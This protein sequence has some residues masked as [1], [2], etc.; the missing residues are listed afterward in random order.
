MAIVQD[1]VTGAASIANGSTAVTGVGTAW[2]AASVRPG[3]LFMRAG[4]AVPI[5]SVTDNTHL[6]LAENWPGTTLAG[7]TYRI[8]FQ[9]DGS[10][11]TAAATALIELL[12]DGDLAAIAALTSAA[13]KLPYFT[14]PGTAGLADFT[15]YARS[16]L[17][18]ADEPSLQANLGIVSRIRK[19]VFTASGTYT[20]DP[21]ML[22][23][24][25]MCLGAGGG[26]GGITGTASAATG[27][28]GGGAGS[29]SR[30]VLSKAD[31]GSSITITVGAGGNGGAAGNN[32]GSAGGD[33]GNGLICTGKGGS[34]GTFVVSGQGTGG[35]GGVAG[36]GDE[37]GN[38]ATGTSVSQ[39]SNILG[40]GGA[41]ASSPYG[42]GGRPAAAFAS[43]Q[44]GGNA[45]GKGA[46][47]SGASAHNSTSTAA[48]GDGSPGYVVILE[49]CVE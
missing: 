15:A 8:R 43:V 13:D 14:G 30:K 4:F 19:Q 40:I 28:G 10:R 38:G 26:G 33:S 18:I 42:G 16:L 37:T 32:N 24:H 31:I 21:K 5:A 41:G 12:A 48:G 23:C 34:G 17:A 29:I 9:P 27:S 20:P 44:P 46:G 3:D 25:M 6:V 22:Y 7:S 49:Y 47:G 35:S 36:L 1:Y 2:A 11:Y 45:T 39:S